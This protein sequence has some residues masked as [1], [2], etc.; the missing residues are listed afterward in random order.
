MGGGVGGVDELSGD[1]AVRDLLRQ[2][3]GLGDGALH[4]LRALG[5]H[6]LGAVGLHQLAALDA[7][8]LRHDDDDAVAARGGHGGKADAR[9]AGGRLDDDGAGLQLALGLRL[10]DHRLGDTV[11]HAAGGVEVLQLREDARLELLGL[12]D[13]GQ[14]QQGGLADQLV[15]G[16]I[17]L[18][19]VRFLLNI[20]QVKCCLVVR[21]KVI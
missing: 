7:H 20:C 3:V 4:A 13:M 17:N 21:C 14:L 19:H 10:I 5:Q 11:L 16:S 6:Q 15:S 8:R 18:A 12:F 9:V 1:E 2:L